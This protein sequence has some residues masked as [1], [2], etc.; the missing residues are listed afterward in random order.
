VSPLETAEQATLPSAQGARTV[1]GAEAADAGR[2]VVLVLSE[3]APA[4]RLWGWSRLVLQRW[5]LRQVPGLMFSKVLG[6]GYEGG[7]GL[8]PSGTRQGLFLGFDNLQAAQAF[9]H[10]SPVLEAYR[11]RSRECCV[12][13]LQ[14]TSSKGSWSGTA[15]SVQGDV[16]SSGPIAS[17][18]RAS[19]KPSRLAAFWRM[20][21]A[22]ER[23]LQQAPGC[24]LA[25]GLGEAPVLRQCTFSLWRDQAALDAYARSGAHLQAIKAAYAGQHFSESM[26]VR[27]APLLVQGRWKGRTFAYGV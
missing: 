2:V 23:S 8:R 22:A 24:E 3:F 27:F 21:P 26:F 18:T 17:L 10:D 25:V 11:Q 14:A 4:Y 7:F 5:P 9:V 20:Q 1:S 6:S 12:A 16:H 15:L 13:V 19:I